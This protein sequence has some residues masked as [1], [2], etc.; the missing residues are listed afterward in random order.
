MALEGQV[1]SFSLETLELEKVQFETKT[2]S[3]QAR[4]MYRWA[5]DS[6]QHHEHFQ[7]RM[8]GE[9]KRMCAY[10]SEECTY[11]GKLTSGTR[12]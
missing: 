2:V 5:Q 11:S 9:A 3:E 1:E 7:Q 6:R 12:A 8:R 10:V 4:Y